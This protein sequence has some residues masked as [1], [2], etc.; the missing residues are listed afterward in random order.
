MHYYLLSLKHV[1]PSS[2]CK[3]VTTGNISLSMN[4]LPTLPDQFGKIECGGT[5]SLN[6]NKL[7]TLPRSFH[8]IGVGGNL[9]LGQ[10]NFS[11]PLKLPSVG[12]SVY[13]VPD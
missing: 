5:L 8:T 10:N 2:F 3:L 6:Q 7:S 13:G 4:R 11:A 1:L 12:G 9:N